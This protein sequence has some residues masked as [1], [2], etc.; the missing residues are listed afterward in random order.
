[1]CKSQKNIH[2]FDKVSIMKEMFQTINCL[3]FWGKKHF[4]KTIHWAISLSHKRHQ[5]YSYLTLVFKIHYLN[6]EMM[7]IKRCERRHIFKIAFVGG[8]YTWFCLININET[9]IYECLLCSRA[10][11][12][13]ILKTWRWK[14]TSSLQTMKLRELRKGMSGQASLWQCDTSHNGASADCGRSTHNP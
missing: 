8:L 13:I 9:N 1:M 12:C 7:L 6:P 10:L 4:Q 14:M 2:Y 11:C 3:Q 5:R